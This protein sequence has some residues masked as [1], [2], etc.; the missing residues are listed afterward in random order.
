MINFIDLSNK[1]IVVTGASSGIGKET[2]ILL[3]KLG[4]RLILVARRGELLEETIKNMDGSGH[5]FYAFDL[6][7]TDEIGN[8]AKRIINENGA[9]DGLAYVAGTG[10][11]VPISLFSPEKIEAVFRLNYFGFIELVRQL[12]KKGRFNPGMRI[13]GVSSIASVCGDPAHTAY[14]GSKAALDGSVRCLAKELAGKS[15]AIN[16]VAPAMTETA[17]FAGFSKNYGE[18]SES[19]KYLLQRQYLGIAK[20]VDIANAIA[21]LISPAARFITGTTLFVDGGYTSC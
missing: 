8:L 7:Q 2:A 17:M 16:T 21:F 18:G 10:K 20:P 13:V 12:T 15:I 6:S 9:I 4:A 1:T 14:S 11:S 3:S 5:T 19:Q